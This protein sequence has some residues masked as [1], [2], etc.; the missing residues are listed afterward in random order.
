[1]FLSVISQ[2][3]LERKDIKLV[4]E[5]CAIYP[6]KSEERKLGGGALAKQGLL[7]LLRKKVNYIPSTGFRI[8]SQTNMS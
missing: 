6:G 4:K 8:T 7:T 1:V 3:L 5:N 2:C